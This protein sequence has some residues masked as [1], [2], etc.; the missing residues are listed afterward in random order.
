MADSSNGGSKFQPPKEMS[1]ELRLLLALLLTVPI[2]F[3]RPYFFGSKTPP[4][5]KDATPTSVTPAT[6]A[7]KPAAA[8]PQTPKVALKTANSSS[9]SGQATDQQPL[10]ST[11]IQTDLYRISFSNQGGTVR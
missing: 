8:E 10:P 7:E 1:M 6:S 11:V 5:R 9:L 4:P 2:L 3:I